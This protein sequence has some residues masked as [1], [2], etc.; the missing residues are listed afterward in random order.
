MREFLLT[1]GKMASGKL[2]PQ[3]VFFNFGVAQAIVVSSDLSVESG[4]LSFQ[5]LLPE[6]FVQNRRLRIG[7]PPPRLLFQI[8]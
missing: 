7:T 8:R 1:Q 2:T 5:V 6:Q 3:S 4:S